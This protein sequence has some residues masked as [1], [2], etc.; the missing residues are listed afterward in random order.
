VET[1]LELEAL[2][3]DKKRRIGEKGF[4]FVVFTNSFFEL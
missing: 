4:F 3:R 1:Y 2:K